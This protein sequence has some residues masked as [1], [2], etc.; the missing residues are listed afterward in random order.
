MNTQLSQEEVQELTGYQYTSY[1]VEWL[2]KVGIAYTING[3]GNVVIFRSWID[4]PP[5]NNHPYVTP[6]EDKID[7]SH[8]GR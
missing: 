1:Q 8:I 7:L 2:Q 3:A 4:K 5:S 6:K